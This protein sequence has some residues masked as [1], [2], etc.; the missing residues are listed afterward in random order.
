MLALLWMGV[1]EPCWIIHLLIYHLLLQGI[2]QLFQKV[3]IK[4]PLPPIHAFM[5]IEANTYIVHIC[6][7]YS[8][9]CVGLLHSCVLTVK[10]VRGIQAVICLL[11]W[12]GAEGQ[13]EWY[14][15]P[16]AHCTYSKATVTCIRP[17]YMFAYIYIYLTISW[18]IVQLFKTSLS[19]DI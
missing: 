3:F 10:F 9:I 12:T 16:F 8:C 5:Q 14:K 17:A 11:Y 1:G 18:L 6:L 19:V 13:V 7:W 2:M 15:M 4:I